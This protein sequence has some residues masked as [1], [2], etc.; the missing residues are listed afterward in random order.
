M[1]VYYFE[2]DTSRNLSTLNLLE[3]TE[4]TIT[5]T[6]LLSYK[7]LL[8]SS[9]FCTYIELLESEEKIKIFDTDLNLVNSIDLENKPIVSYIFEYKIAILF[10]RNGS[11][12]D[13]YISIF[14][15]DGFNI[16]KTSEINIGYLNST[17]DYILIL[18]QN[19]ILYTKQTLLSYNLCLFDISTNVEYELEVT[20]S[21]IS[22]AAIWIDNF[23]LCCTKRDDIL[24]IYDSSTGLQI[25]ELRVEYGILDILVTET[26][27][28]IT[29]PYIDNIIQIYNKNLPF[30]S[31]EEKIDLKNLINLN[32]GNFEGIFNIIPSSSTDEIFIHY[33]TIVPGNAIISLDLNTN[34]VKRIKEFDV[35]ICYV[36]MILNIN[37]NFK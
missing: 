26:K 37:E 10:L 34:V 9:V 32:F 12:K 19:K 16:N 27:I 8:Y 5:P 7:T 31:L 29:T 11:D 18:N 4:N 35:E 23:I 24:K 15:F 21:N 1:L 13:Y 30:I 22:K 6:E 28:I 33:E 14:D 36:G 17:Y 25:K 2:T 3:N 20:N